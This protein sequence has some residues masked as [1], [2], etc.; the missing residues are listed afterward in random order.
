VILGG[1][2]MPSPDGLI[3]C[4]YAAESALQFKEAKIIIALPYNED[5]KDSLRQLR[6]MQHE[7]VIRGVDSTRI[8]FEP[9]GFNTHSQAINIAGMLH[10]K[11]ESLVIVSSPEHIYRAIKTFK[12]A[13]FIHVSGLAAFE[14]PIDEEKI[15][16]KEN[17]K[18]TRIK[19]LTARYNI[20]SYLG[21]E[22]LVLKELNALAYYWVKGWI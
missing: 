16:D 4:Y 20:W 2:G 19:N 8:S 13:G 21:Y 11:T 7:L 15:K 17:T 22:L 9:L 5:E 3:R 6:L 10:T 1:G 12:K 14:I 18:D